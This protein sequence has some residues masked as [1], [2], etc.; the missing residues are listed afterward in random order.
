MIAVDKETRYEHGKK[1]TPL[2]QELGAAGTNL[3]QAHVVIPNL[4]PLI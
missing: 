1:F 3:T 4:L 2:L